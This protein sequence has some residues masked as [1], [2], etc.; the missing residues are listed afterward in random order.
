MEDINEKDF[1]INIDN[2]NVEEIMNKIRKKIKK[3]V[4]EYYENNGN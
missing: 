2:I 4:E 3:K 1:E